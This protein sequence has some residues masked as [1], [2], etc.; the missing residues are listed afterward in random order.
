MRTSDTI[1]RMGGDEFAILPSGADSV[2]ELVVTA[3][4]VLAATK[5]PFVIL[6][7]DLPVR[8][9]IGIAAFPDHGADVATLMRKA[10]VAM[11]AAKQVASG[12]AVYSSEQDN[13]FNARLALYKELREAISGGELELHFQPKVEI[14][15][16]RTVAME[17]LA[18]WPHRSRGFL[19]PDEFIPLAEESDQI[20]PL[21]RWV[22]KRALNQL[23]E[24]RGTG[25][26]TVVCVNLSA[27]NLAEADL[28]DHIKELLEQSRLPPGKVILEITESTLIPRSVDACL[29]GLRALGVGLSID[30]YGTGYSSLMHLRRL[31]LTELKLDRTFVREVTTVSRARPPSGTCRRWTATRPRVS[32]SHRLCPP[33]TSPAGCGLPPGRPRS[34]RAYT[35][36]ERPFSTH[37]ICIS[38]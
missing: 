32:T 33:A 27:R 22:L 3:Q 4:K 25:I 37:D 21:T 26:D 30:D 7:N 5:E 31:P 24:W 16:R 34:E 28:V 18:R 11:Y 13:Q 19:P 1:A 6:G 35:R 14:A 38:A 36:S 23:C 9:S 15:T 8:A 29:R 2:P 17:A 20:T 10:D 12:Y